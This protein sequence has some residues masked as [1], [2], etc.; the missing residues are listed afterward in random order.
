MY[1]DQA[2]LRRFGDEYYIEYHITALPR[3]EQIGSYFVRRWR[4]IMGIYAVAAEF[5][6]LPEAIK[7]C[8]ERWNVKG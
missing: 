2:V 6:T 1:R 7:F 8:Q 5:A 3:G 4:P